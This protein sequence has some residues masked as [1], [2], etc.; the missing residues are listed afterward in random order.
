MI[1][2]YDNECFSVSSRPFEYFSDR[3]VEIQNFLYQ[4]IE[5][6]GMSIVVDL[7]GFHHQKESFFIL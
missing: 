2:C 1:C 7:G 3:T 4:R 5:L 6:I